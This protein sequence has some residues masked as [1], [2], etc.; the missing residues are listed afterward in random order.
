VPKKTVHEQNTLYEE[1]KQYIKPQD[2]SVKNYIP[3]PPARNILQKITADGKN[4][5]TPP[6]HWA[7]RLL[8]EDY[9]E[10]L[11][12]DET[13]NPLFLATKHGMVWFINTVLDSKINKK[14]LSGIL[15]PSSKDEESSSSSRHPNCIAEAITQELDAT[16]VLKLI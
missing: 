15:G 8:V 10:L 2:E 4:D 13:A 1:Y 12:D 11:E 9:P 3:S 6:E 16:V 5:D 14:K 7:V